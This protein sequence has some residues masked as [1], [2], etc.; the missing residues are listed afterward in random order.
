MKRHLLL[1]FAMLCLLLNF[2]EA[3]AQQNLFV[4]GDITRSEFV[5]LDMKEQQRIYRDMSAGQ[6]EA[7]WTYKF[8]IS[9]KDQRLTPSEKQELQN[10]MD[11]MEIPGFFDNTGNLSTEKFIRKWTHK[12]TGKYGWSEDKLFYYTHTW[13]TD[14][15]L[16]DYEKARGLETNPLRMSSGSAWYEIEQWAK[17]HL[18]YYS[19]GQH[20]EE[21][22]SLPL[23]RQ[24]A[25]YRLF[26][27]KEKAL[28]WN[29]KLDN[30]QN[31]TTL[32]ETEKEAVLSYYSKYSP[33]GRPD[34][35]DERKSAKA[36]KYKEARSD[37]RYNMENKFGW[38]N[39]KFWSYCE[40]WL[41]EAEWQ[42]YCRANGIKST[43]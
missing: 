27:R 34:G 24:N 23:N 20:R 18:E 10:M 14:D 8:Q 35:M 33:L 26:T 2:I 11:T 21:F 38:D 43:F 4:Y 3:A 40:I 36:R 9:L 41:T 1:T 16:R 29:K 25:L 5:K 28:L 37:M 7:L 19:S 13:M 6:K 22:V 17:E 42:Q 15:E 12:M 30:I 39:R 31:S 32:S